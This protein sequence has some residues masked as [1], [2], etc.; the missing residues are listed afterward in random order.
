MA[1]KTPRVDLG[2]ELSLW[3]A[4]LFRLCCAK[5]H[6]TLRLDSVPP[7]HLAHCSLMFGAD[8]WYSGQQSLTVLITYTISQNMNIC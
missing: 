4:S 1:A 8:K 2:E 3:E 6:L 5:K 7:A